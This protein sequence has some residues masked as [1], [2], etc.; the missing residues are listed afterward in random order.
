MSEDPEIKIKY[1][2]KKAR[3]S[4]YWKYFIGQSKGLKALNVYDKKVKQENGTRNMSM[5]HM[6]VKRKYKITVLERVLSL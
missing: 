6:F 4:N 3:V 5:M 2:S 1:A